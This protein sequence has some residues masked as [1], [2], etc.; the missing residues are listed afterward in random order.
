[1][2]IANATSMTARV[3]LYR[4][5]V[6]MTEDAPR[7]AE[8]IAAELDHVQ[9]ETPMDAARAMAIASK[10]L[11]FVLLANMMLSQTERRAFRDES[12]PA[13]EKVVSIFEPHTAS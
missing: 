6:R 4:D 3:P 8:W 7:Q 2:G 5:L 12:V 11:N 9:C 10:I 1:M 13:E